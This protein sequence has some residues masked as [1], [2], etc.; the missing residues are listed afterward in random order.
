[1]PPQV[2]I[3]FLTRGRSREEASTARDLASLPDGA[4]RFQGELR[5]LGPRTDQGR[6]HGSIGDAISSLASCRYSI[7][8]DNFYDRLIQGDEIDKIVQD[9]R[10]DMQSRLNDDLLIGTPV[11]YMQSLSGQLVRQEVELPSEGKLD[12]HHVSTKYPANSSGDIRQRLS[13]AAWSEATDKASAR[14][15]D[16]WINGRQLVGRSLCE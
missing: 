5:A 11:L 7:H 16:R 2:V 3:E 6:N 4:C 13:G 15:V 14:E 1:M 9:I 12:P 10:W 8:Q